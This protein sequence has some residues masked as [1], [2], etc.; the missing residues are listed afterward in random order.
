MY[1]LYHILSFTVK[2]I[3]SDNIIK[4][5]SFTQLR[6]VTHFNHLQYKSIGFNGFE[7]NVLLVPIME[8]LNWARKRKN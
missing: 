8:V 3:F 5:L 2:T 1:E 6:V 7:M 4:Q